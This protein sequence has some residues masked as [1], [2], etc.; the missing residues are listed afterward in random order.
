MALSNTFGDVQHMLAYARVHGM[1]NLVL[2]LGT[3]PFNGN[4]LPLG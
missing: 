1:G 3:E 2:A 4:Q